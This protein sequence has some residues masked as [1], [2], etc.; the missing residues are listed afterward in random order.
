MTHGRAPVRGTGG[1]IE[2]E[3]SALHPSGSVLARRWPIVV[4]A[5]VLMLLAACGSPSAGGGTPPNPAAKPPNGGYFQLQPLGAVPNLPSDRAAGGMVHR[6]TW[7]PR[8]DNAG[9]NHVMPPPDFRP[10]GYS[11]MVNGPAVFDRISGAFTGTTDETLQWAAVKWGLPDDVLRGMAYVDSQWYQAHKDPDG[12]PTQGQGYGGF[13][14]CG[15]APPDS[16]YGPDGPS[17][18]GITGVSW[19]A[20][21]D[22]NQPGSGGWPWTENSTA[23][24]ADTTG[25]IVRACYEGWEPQWG[26][27]YHPGDLWGCVG[28]W[29][30]NAWGTLDGKNYSNRVQDAIATKPWLTW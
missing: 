8:P 5:T 13:G 9:P 19:C 10:A 2:G 20:F 28:R 24:A 16:P 21:N 12:K 22:P 7:E 17:K 15:G 27:T 14:Q 4:A 29:Y 1:P 11:G 18:F 3:G 6:S 23:Y 30:A 25:A 26:P